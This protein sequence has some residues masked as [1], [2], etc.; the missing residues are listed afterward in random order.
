MP[1]R[2]TMRGNT[3]IAISPKGEAYPLYQNPPTG[4][5]VEKGRFVPQIQNLQW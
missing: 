5:L 4:R 3:V 2:L 1:Y